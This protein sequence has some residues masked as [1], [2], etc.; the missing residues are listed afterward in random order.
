MT[1]GSSYFLQHTVRSLRSR[2]SAPSVW[3]E[4]WPL[5][6]PETSGAQREAHE[7]MDTGIRRCNFQASEIENMGLIIVALL[8]GLCH[9]CPS[10]LP[11][12]VIEATY[13]L[14]AIVSRFN[15][16]VLRWTALPA[17]SLRGVSDFSGE[18]GSARSKKTN[19]CTSGFALSKLGLGQC[20]QQVFVWLLPERDQ[21][22]DRPNTTRDHFHT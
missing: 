7:I 17:A 13:G 8:S 19:S 1:R 21:D 18:F 5:R 11:L 6:Q 22:P 2:G 4:P 16:V 14:I 12:S 10:P 3:A 20:Q 15:S 9:L